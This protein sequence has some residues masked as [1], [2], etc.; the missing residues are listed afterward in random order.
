LSEASKSFSKKEDKLLFIFFEDASEHMLYKQQVV[1]RENEWYL[2]L[3][4]S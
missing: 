3:Y 4:K 1:Q 2:Q